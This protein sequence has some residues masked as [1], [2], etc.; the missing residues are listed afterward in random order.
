MSS[1]YSPLPSQQPPRGADPVDAVLPPPH[2]SVL[3]EQALAA[4]QPPLHTTL[5]DL[6]VF[7]TTE[8]QVPRPTLL[9]SEALGS[10]RPAPSVS[11]LPATDPPVPPP[12][13]VSVLPPETLPALPTPKRPNLVRPMPQSQDSQ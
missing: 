1:D 3:P 6:S 5:L 4:I 8:N 11:V 9:P 12:T 2:A 10:D 13:G 7:P